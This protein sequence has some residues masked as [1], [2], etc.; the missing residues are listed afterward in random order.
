MVSAIS[1][2]VFSSVN[3]FYKYLKNEQDSKTTFKNIGKDVIKGTGH[4]LLSS[5]IANV[6]KFG[7]FKTGNAFF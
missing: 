6:V 3:N 2:C 4:G 1:S 7:A 5:S